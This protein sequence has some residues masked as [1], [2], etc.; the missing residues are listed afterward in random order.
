MNSFKNKIDF[1]TIE[2]DGKAYD[3][4]KYMPIPRIG[5]EVCLYDSKI[6]IVKSVLYQISNNLKMITITTENI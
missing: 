1:I 5:E 2:I 3:Y 6:A 4:P